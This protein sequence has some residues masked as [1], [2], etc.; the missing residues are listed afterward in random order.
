[1]ASHDFKN[2]KACQ[3]G[4][5]AWEDELQPLMREGGTFDYSA[6]EASK[7]RL[8]E[9]KTKGP[10]HAGQCPMHADLRGKEFGA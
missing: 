5:A 10:H 2:C 4:R 1:V 7:S 6:I 8:I 3:E 9:G